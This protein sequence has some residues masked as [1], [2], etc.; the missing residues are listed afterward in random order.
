MNIHQLSV[1]YH[2]D[3]D[4]ILV[5]INTLAGEELRLWLTRRLV[6]NFLPH[7]NRLVIELEAGI[8]QLTNHDDLSKKAVA[9]FKKQASIT[10]SDFKTP[11]TTQAS[12]Y[13]VGQEPLLVTSIHLAPDGKGALRIGF[14]EKMLDQP[15]PR[16]FHMT[17]ASSLLHGFTHLLESA[18]K[19][20]EWG[21]LDPQKPIPDALDA[22][23]EKSR[24]SDPPT[25][26]N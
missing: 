16:G 1:A 20:S 23:L 12:G 15:A 14:E 13:P 25:Y 22:A 24:P 2:V 10:H 8:L 26:L 6:V 3:H 21:I 5:L 19:A 17:M 4:R 11:F 18:I 9:E 7:L